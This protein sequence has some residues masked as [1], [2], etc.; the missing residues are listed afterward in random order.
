MD[1]ITQVMQQS[2]RIT[3]PLTDKSYQHHEAKKI[4]GFIN[5][6]E[7]Y[8]YTLPYRNL[9]LRLTLFIAHG[10]QVTVPVGLWIV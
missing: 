10:S 1:G 6:S 4:L 3:S 8:L 7:L 9:M 5:R 2:V